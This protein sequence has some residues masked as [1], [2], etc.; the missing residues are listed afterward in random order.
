LQF[1]QSSLFLAFVLATAGP[2]FADHIAADSTTGAGGFA[3]SAGATQQES[4]Q[5][6]SFTRTSDMRIFKEGKGVP[7]GSEAVQI[8]NFTDNTA[9]SMT[10]M[11]L[12][13]ETGS[14]DHKESIAEFGLLHGSSAGDNMHKDWAE[15]VT[16]SAVPVPEPDSKML[17][18]VGLSGLGI[19]VYLRHLLRIAV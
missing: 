5:N 7:A 14:A 16:P 1:K 4:L 13:V 6:A 9:N 12:T 18:L 15:C 17:L 19:S 11:P 8:F 3:S 2:A 10:G